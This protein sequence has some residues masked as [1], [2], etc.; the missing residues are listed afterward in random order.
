MERPCYS[1]NCGEVTGT[2]EVTGKIVDPTFSRNLF[3]EHAADT[4]P[5]FGDS[6]RQVNEQ[7]LFPRSE[8]ST[9]ST[10]PTVVTRSSRTRLGSGGVAEHFGG[11]AFVPSSSSSSSSNQGQGGCSGEQNA[12]TMDESRCD[13]RTRKHFA[14]SPTSVLPNGERVERELECPIRGRVHF[15]ERTGGRNDG[16]RWVSHPE[17]QHFGDPVRKESFPFPR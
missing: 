9:G 11:D 12:H 6:T 4:S 17:R 8:R 7:L 3:E 15:P 16:D 13:P 2:A 10:D 5:V 14:P 1:W